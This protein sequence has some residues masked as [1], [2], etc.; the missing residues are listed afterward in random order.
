[1]Q[2]GDINKFYN[3]RGIKIACYFFFSSALGKQ[4][5]IIDVYV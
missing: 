4:F 2:N 1:M 5:F 3:V